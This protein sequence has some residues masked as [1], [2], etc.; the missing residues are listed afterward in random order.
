MLGDRRAVGGEPLGQRP[1]E[2]RRER[3][4]EG[5]QQERQRDP[6]Q[7]PAQPAGFVRAHSGAI[8]FRSHACSRLIATSTANDAASIVA[9]IAVAPA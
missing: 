2:H 4:R 5:E 1:G 6:D 8:R 7:R 9:A 3:Q